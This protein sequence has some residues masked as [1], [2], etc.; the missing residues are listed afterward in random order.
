M[1]YYTT[2]IPQLGYASVVWI[3]ITCTDASKLKR[4]QKMFM[5]NSINNQLDATITIY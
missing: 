5:Y 1:I 4:V 2:V 3:A